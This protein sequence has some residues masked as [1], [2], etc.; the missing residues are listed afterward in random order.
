MA[1]MVVSSDGEFGIELCKVLGLDPKKTKNIIIICKVDSAVMIQTTS[2]LMEDE[3]GGL[4]KLIKKY[5]LE[6]ENGK[7]E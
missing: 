6:E 2:Y 1:R 3:T 4:F 7:K 5:H